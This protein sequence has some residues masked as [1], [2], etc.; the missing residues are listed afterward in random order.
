MKATRSPSCKRRRVEIPASIKKMI[1]QRKEDHLK[2]TIQDIRQH[3]IA[4]YS[5]DTGKSTVVDIIKKQEQMVIC[6]LIFTVFV[7]TSACYYNVNKKTQINIC[8][9]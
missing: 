1:C 6:T 9:H 3:I 8:I 4:D 5:L 7:H 2:A